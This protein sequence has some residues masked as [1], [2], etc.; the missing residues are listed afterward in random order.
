MNAA[1]YVHE[2][3]G[4]FFIGVKTGARY[5][6]PLNSKSARLSGCSGVYG[7]AD[8]C[9][10]SAW[11]YSRRSDALRKARELYDVK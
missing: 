1:N 7:P 11:N 4:R 2:Y 5:E 9:V 8:Y 3:N 6:C 10:G